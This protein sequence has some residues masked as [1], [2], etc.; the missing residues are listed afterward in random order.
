M[1]DLPHHMQKLNRR[2]VR[3]EHRIIE[4]ELENPEEIPSQ[5]PRFERP[6]E[7]IRKQKKEIMRKN[8]RAQTP[9]HLNED[10]RNQKMKHRVPIFDRLSHPKPKVGA[11]QKKKA[12]RY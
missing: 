5:T 8:T 9:Q 2:V 12:P 10:E 7:Q 4:M 3:S 6:G 11:K 1:K